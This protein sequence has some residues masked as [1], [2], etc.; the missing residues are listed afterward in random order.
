MDPQRWAEIE[1]L[2]HAALAKEPAERSSYLEAACA[3]DP[4]LRK[5][6]IEEGPLPR[7]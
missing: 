5:E 2:Y 1:P 4:A 3:E 7:S 6:G